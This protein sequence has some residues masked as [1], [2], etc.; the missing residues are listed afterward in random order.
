[1]KYLKYIK[2]I[3]PIAIIASL[4]IFQ[5]SILRELS[6]LS[7]KN[8][9]TGVFNKYEDYDFTDG[10]KTFK[11][12]LLEIGAETCPSCR[13]MKKVIERIHD[14]YAG[15]LHVERINITKKEG[16]NKAKEFGLIMIPMQ[17]LLNQKGELVY[18]HTGYI[19]FDDLSEKIEQYIQH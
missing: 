13:R 16:L 1:M 7:I 8:Q 9:R 2:V 10:E 14:H 19:S 12:S 18:R 6:E 3:L 4:F 17:V 11:A 15:N 5:K